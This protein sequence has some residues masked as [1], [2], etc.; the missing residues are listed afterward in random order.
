M[1][2][3]GLGLLFLLG[4]NK[5]IYM[6][7]LI[8]QIVSINEEKEYLPQNEEK[9]DKSVQIKKMKNLFVNFIILKPTKEI[10]IMQK[11]K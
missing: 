8:Q 9:K 1:N 3:L 6:E 7:D 4:E 5:K 10:Q 2:N 11:V